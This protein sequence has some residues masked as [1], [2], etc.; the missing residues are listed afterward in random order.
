[1]RVK[2]I[3]I[4]VAILLLSF[5]VTGCSKSSNISSSPPANPVYERV[6]QSGTIRCGYFLYPPYCMK[7]PNTGKFSGIFVDVLEEAGKNLGFKIKWTEE[8][9]LGTMIEGLE[10]NRYDLVPTGVWPNANRARHASFS[11]PLFY[12]GV[13]VWV[14]SN[15]N[16]FNNNLQAINSE[17]VRIAAVDG[18]I[19]Q[20]IAKNQFPHARLLALPEMSDFTQLML[21]VV[22]KKAD[23]IFIEP[24][25]GVR[26][27]K[28]N[29]GTIKNI[30][31]NK[32]ISV[33]A[34]TMM[35]KIGDSAFK[36]MLDTAL[37]ELVNTGYVD[38]VLSKYAPQPG[39]YYRLAPPYVVER[40]N[41]SK[42]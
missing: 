37:T 12:S 22:D 35:F 21:D 9:G 18:T 11:A 28:H 38:E 16:R 3:Q 17:S 8:V 10:S 41:K 24:S 7:D 20:L 36:S 14:R 42:D 31:E 19:E 25:G 39:V 40:S 2:H 30:A 6:M 4:L 15:D 1:M 34:N 13:G 29:P 5:L 32:P 26:F 33:F 27:L 23:V